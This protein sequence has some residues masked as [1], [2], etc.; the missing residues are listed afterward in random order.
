MEIPIAEYLGEEY[1]HSDA[2]KP[3]YIYAL[4][5]IMNVLYTYGMETSYFRFCKTEDKLKL[6]RTQLTMI[7][8]STAFFS[9]LL[10]LFR[11]QVAA[12]AELGE[13]L[14]YV[15]W[16]AGIIALDTLSALPYARLRQENRPRKYAFTK[17]AGIIVFV[18][19]IVFLF[20]SAKS[21]ARVTMACSRLAK[22][23]NPMPQCR[24]YHWAK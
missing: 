10:L 9:L 22:R 1:F 16:C 14:T 18:C 4:F 8:A 13:N 7:L 24:S 21:S 15:G 5:P 12:F 2:S 3:G 23:I 11:E 19:T 20:S 17:I 6:Y